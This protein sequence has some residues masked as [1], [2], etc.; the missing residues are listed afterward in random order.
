MLRKM[1]WSDVGKL[2]LPSL[3]LHYESSLIARRC[4][5][6]VTIDIPWSVCIESFHV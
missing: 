4:D 2:F 1:S 5:R 6:Q 3:F